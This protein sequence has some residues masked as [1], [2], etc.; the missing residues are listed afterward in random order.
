MGWPTGK[1]KTAEEVA[2]RVV[3]FKSN[4]SNRKQPRIVDGRKQWFCPKCK[5]W[6]D[7]DC[8]YKTTRTWS[9]VR[10][11]CKKCHTESVMRTRDPVNTR[12]IRRENMSRARMKD[13]DKFRARGR[14]NA[15]KLVV[16]DQVVARR[17]LNSAVRSGSVKRPCRCEECGRSRPVHGHHRDYSKPLVV[18]WLCSECHGRQH[19]NDV[20]P[21]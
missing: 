10:N 19:W 8:F 14:A 3:T 11:H 18:N 20:G 16:T 1:K 15:K 21:S 9:G 12:R 6:L 5:D 2:R 4:E 7:E 13:P 17:V